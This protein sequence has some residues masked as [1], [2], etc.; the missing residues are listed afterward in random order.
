VKIRAVHRDRLSLTGIALTRG[1]V[2]DDAGRKDALERA[3]PFTLL[4]AY[5]IRPIGDLQREHQ[6]L[7][8]QQERDPA[9]DD[10]ARRDPVRPWP[11]SPIAP[12]DY[13]L[14]RS[15]AS[16][17]RRGIIWNVRSVPIRSRRPGLLDA[18]KK[19]AIVAQI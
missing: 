15:P 19:R 12:G 4:L 16:I 5:D 13:L 14:V 6:L 11:A 9:P 8:D 2:D 18:H 7:L 10:S 1:D 17:A 3:V